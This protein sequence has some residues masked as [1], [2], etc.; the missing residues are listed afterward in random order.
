MSLSKKDKQWLLKLSRATLEGL[1]DSTRKPSLENVEIPSSVTEKRGA[2]V[3]LKKKGQL[4]GCIGYVEELMPLYKAV[5]EN[6]E[7]AALK[8]PRFPPLHKD[9]VSQVSIE[10][11][12]MS[13]LTEISGID[14]IKVG[15][16]GLVVE[17]GF[18]RGLLLPQVAVEHE[19]NEQQFLE[20]TCLKA[21]LPAESWKDDNTRIYVFSAEVFSEEDEGK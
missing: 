21:G 19:M 1:F 14:E 3:T 15:K 16:H 4:R 7:N 10:I 9:E 18:F 6:T 13:P 12:A 20:Q 5:M 11:S 17:Q 8:D 2:F